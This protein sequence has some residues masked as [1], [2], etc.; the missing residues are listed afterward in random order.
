METIKLRVT[1]GVFIHGCCYKAGDIVSMTDVH[2]IGDV[3]QGGRAALLDPSQLDKVQS[4]IRRS[5]NFAVELS[6][7]RSAL[8][9]Q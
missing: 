9:C 5:T 6:D 4:E 3:L 2:A 7:R 8:G 1:R